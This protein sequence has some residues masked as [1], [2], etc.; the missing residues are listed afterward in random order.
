MISFFRHAAVALDLSEASDL[1]V[2]CVSTFHNLGTKKITLVTVLPVPYEKEGTELDTSKEKNQLEEYQKTLEQ[3]G[4]E[5]DIRI[6][7]GLNYY[8][9]TEI[10]TAANEVNA[11]F[12]VISNRGQSKVLE[13]LSGSI[14][15][16]LLQRSELPVYLINLDLIENPEKSG[17]RSLKLPQPCNE[18]VKHVLYATD[19]SDSAY[20][21]YK[22][23]RD[24]EGA[25][26]VDRIS[27]IHVQGHHAIAIK[28]PVSRDR[29][30]EQNREQLDR[31]RNKL[32]DRT[33]EETE[34]IITYGTPAK[35]IV[36]TA[37]ERNA[38]MIMMGSQGEG[39]VKDLFL[40]S[41]SS[42]VTRLSDIPVLLIPAERV[43]EES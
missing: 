14:S 6:R 33:R 10:L 27:M 25:G 30:T 21:T 39:Y 3:A 35:E 23:L 4:F 11:D 42:K 41:V 36:N 19:F 1:I 12:V 24:M 2:E 22:V 38:T 31:I 5:V 32:S 26:I 28:D 37:K 34:L 16:E 29:L 13:L 9:P 40:G 43:D 7:S 18:A 17:G 20:R 15:T 8:P